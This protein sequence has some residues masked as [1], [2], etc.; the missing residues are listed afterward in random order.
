MVTKSNQV[1]DGSMISVGFENPDY[2][3]TY[4][5]MKS[6]DYNIEQITEAIFRLPRWA[7]RLMKLRDFI[8]K[9]FGLKTKKDGSANQKFFTVITQTENEI[10]MG[11]NDTHLNFRVSVLADREKNFIYVTTLVR[12]N[13]FL[14]RVYFLPV[15]PFHGI[16]VK[17]LMF[18]LAK[19]CEAPTALG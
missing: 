1:P 8:V 3:D 7:K 12:Y 9:P 4:R 5:I 11:E 2:V 17:S 14:G 13:N 18:R 19:S 16:I 15:K 10:V 6:T